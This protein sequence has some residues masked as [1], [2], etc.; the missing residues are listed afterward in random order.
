ME[1]DK[2]ID[3]IMDVLLSYT[4]K[5][6]AKKIS[7]SSEGDAVD[8]IAVG[9]NTIGEELQAHIS[10]LEASKTELEIRDER[11]KSLINSTNDAIIT[12]DEHSNISI[13]NEGAENIFGFKK[14]DVIG[15][16][17]TKIIPKQYFQRKSAKSD[18]TN[19]FHKPI[20]FK[21]TH[22]N[23]EEV[24]VEM[25]LGSW[26]KNKVTFYIAIIREISERIKTQQ[27]LIK[28]NTAIAEVKDYAIILLDA[29]G[30]VS[31]WNA[32]AEK[33][34]GY[35]A[36]EI[37]GKSFK[38]FYPPSDRKKKKPERSL[39]R[40]FKEGQSED[41]GWRVRKDG[42][43]FWANVTMTAIHDEN[44]D[45][46]GY[47]KITKDLTEAKIA[48]ERLETSEAQ[49]K[50]LI[51]NMM[52][53][54]AHCRIILNK[55]GKPVD[56][57]YLYVNNAFEKQTG[58]NVE[59]T[60][61][62]K[63]SEIL[64]GSLTDAADWVSRYGKVALGGKPAFFVDYSEPLDKWY[65]VS[66]YSPK[67]GEFATIFKDVT[68]RYKSEEAIKKSEARFR[69]LLESA[70]DAMVIVD[71]DGCIQEVNAQ[72]E[73]MFGYSR[74]ELLKSKVEKLMPNNF[75][76]NHKKHRSNFSKNPR[77]RMM[78]EG[79][80]LLGKRKNGQ[81]FPVEV[82]L[83]PIDT[84]KGILVSAAVRD[85]TDRRKAEDLIKNFNEELQMKNEELKAQQEELRQANEE[86]EEHTNLLKQQQEELETTNVELEEQKKEIS[87]ANESLKAA[88]FE[89]QQKAHELELTSRYKSEFLANMSHELRSPLNSMLILS[90]DLAQNKEG[91][92]KE[93]QTESASIIHQ[94]GKELLELINHILDLS[95]IEAGKMEITE[96]TIPLK[97]LEK[98][99][100]DTFG[101]LAKEKKISL[102]THIEKD[103]FPS[104]RSDKQ[105]V[106]QIINNLV[107]NAIK[108]T[109][110]GTV[111][112][113]FASTKSNELKIE[114]KDTGIGIPKE[115]KDLIFE[116]FTQADGGTARKYGGT[117]LGLAISHQLIN[118]LEGS[119]EMQS[120]VDKGSV[121][122]VYLPKK[123][124]RRKA[125]KQKKIQ[126]ET[127]EFNTQF[128]NFETIEDDRD[129]I[130][131][132]DHTLLIIEDDPNFARILRDHANEMTFKSLV[133]A[134]GEDGLMLAE[135]YIPDAII[136]DI[137]LPGISGDVVIQELN[138]H[139]T[140]KNI[141]VHVISAMDSSSFN[142]L[143]VVQYITKPVEKR[144]L[145]RAFEQIERAV[146]GE[147]RKI[148][149]VEDHVPTRKSLKNILKEEHVEI[150]EAGSVMEAKAALESHV[151]DCIVLDLG[152]PDGSGSDVIAKIKASRKDF[153]PPVIV[154]TGRDL[155]ESEINEMNEWAKEIIIKG[156]KSKE[157]LLDEISLFLHH[158]STKSKKAK[159]PT[160]K[161][162]Q[163]ALQKLKNKKVLLVDDDMR[164]VF[165]LSKILT[166]NGLEVLK[167]SNGMKALEI[168]N[169]GENPDLVL[170]D[171]M[172][173][174][175]DGY[176]TMERIRKEKKFKRLPI[177][178]LTAKAMKGDRK[179]CID[180]GANDYMAK[181]VD[182]KKL[183]NLMSVWI[184]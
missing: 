177:I 32:G 152:L 90:G 16:P 105:R 119:I 178:A 109:P 138:N 67:K 4:Q 123:I 130:L 55:K 30:K 54:F 62:K 145:E 126:G 160:A 7:I 35:T 3:E 13:W 60:V 34:K 42:T 112:V 106:K 131:P 84:E 113:T 122:T 64:P 45:V 28:L 173:P 129:N 133:A 146:S 168:L 58:L 161:L 10:D 31:N 143:K 100:H 111:K 162:R 174:E 159:S 43:K 155:D 73:K 22:K 163:T 85:V 87:D 75:A 134:T 79:R 50:A 172:M 5:D 81:E 107:S 184:K 175:M 59:D 24:P 38:N 99:I 68:D 93:D 165:A 20:E 158:S 61:G 40:A 114:V 151:L 23:G 117:G 115:K 139:K 12:T 46:I 148:L 180:A 52:D 89:L 21:L 132:S 153:L 78:G 57:E 181:P 169:S 76:K 37:I 171:I 124:K 92:L 51:E 140:L 147:I 150:V 103:T 120:E 63:I 91:N 125:I 49:S 29:D 72:T 95:K 17:L 156:E 15:K 176:E 128:L 88:Q 179:K 164:N 102:E 137:G 157:R 96:E 74:E 86:L 101:R 144:Q 14:D 25:M 183:I 33:I 47:S 39:K 127:K 48:Q 141:P 166:E 167:A 56:W 98:D 18:K 44:D 142:N 80:E 41:E 136:L 83:S 53:G 71:Q 104:F 116:A 135:K 6:F 110:K 97:A 69:K 27:K 108:F 154:Y 170:M 36:K 70:P 118:L 66:A 77:V 149:L 1:D 121:F 182:I 8:A 94:S 9:V 11:F 19:E 82:S 26:K 2:R 65:E